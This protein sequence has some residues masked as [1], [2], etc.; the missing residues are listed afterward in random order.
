ALGSRTGG[1]KELPQLRD[2]AHESLVAKDFKEITGSPGR[3]LQTCCL[4]NHDGAHHSG[5]KIDHVEDELVRVLGFDIVGRELIVWEIADVER[6]DRL[7]SGPDR[8]S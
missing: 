4:L 3:F 2:R 8:S 5:R 6:D 7:R 1:A